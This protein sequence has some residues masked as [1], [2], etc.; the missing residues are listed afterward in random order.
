MIFMIHAHQDLLG[1]AEEDLSVTANAEELF[2]PKFQIVNPHNFQLAQKMDASAS[3]RL[4]PDIKLLE[5]SLPKP[6]QLIEPLKPLE[7]ME[8]EAPLV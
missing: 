3:L 8:K 6:F 2:H 4:I 1:D 7:P 5:P